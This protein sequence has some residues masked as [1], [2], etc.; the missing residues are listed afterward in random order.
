M[1]KPVYIYVTQDQKSKLIKLKDQKKLSISTIV[2]IIIKHYQYRAAAYGKKYQ[3]KGTYKLHLKIKNPSNYP[4]IPMDILATNCI[5]EYYEQPT[6]EIDYMKINSQVQSEM[7]K[8]SDAFY[9]YNMTIRNQTRAVRQNK[10]Y[11]KRILNQ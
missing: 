1:A 11:Y 9:N 3:S 2:D 6:Q 8:T 5:Y 10:E 4:D 7:D